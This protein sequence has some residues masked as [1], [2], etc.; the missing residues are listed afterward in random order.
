MVHQVLAESEAKLQKRA[1]AEGS[2]EPETEEKDEEEK[3]EETKKE[4]SHREFL[5]VADACDYLSRNF[6]KVAFGKSAEDIPV[7]PQLGSGVAPGGPQSAMQVE[8]NTTTGT[9][10]QPGQSG[11]ATSGNQIPA[12]TE[13][14][15]SPNENDAANAMPTNEGMMMA[16][17]PE[18][19]LKQAADDPAELSQR[20]RHTLGGAAVG[21]LKGSLA[22]V[23]IG[24]L[25]GLASGKGPAAGAAAGYGLGGVVGTG[26][27]GVKGY[28]HG[29]RTQEALAE[30][31]ALKAGTAKTASDRVREKF[32]RAMLG[33]FA[34]DALN[35]AKIEAG[36]EPILQRA[37]GTNP[38]Q[39]QGTPVGEGTPR[40]TAP[41]DGQGAGR[42]L[43]SSNMAAIG[44][45]K[46]DA[47]GPQKKPLAELL[48]EPALN[49]A[50][51]TVL[52]QSLDSTS[53][54]GVKIS[55]ARELLKAA[56]ASS[57]E[58]KA[59][60]DAMIKAAQGE[61]PPPGQGVGGEADAMGASTVSGV[62]DEALAAAAE[63]V[64][65]DELAKAQVILAMQTA[66]P[67]GMSEAG[68]EMGIPQGEGAGQEAVPPVE[69]PQ[70][71]A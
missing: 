52:N 46:R 3:E 62:S 19:V 59:I 51:D 2:G 26:V 38:A 40:E 8:P 20:L 22:G 34:E 50:H 47:K 17:Q 63:G 61:L 42:E 14:S 24:A 64:T 68:P 60:I 10:L 56:A 41:T 28:G 43:I 13:P 12:K 32:A 67:G 29:R 25:L 70:M 11:E 4:G 21:G 55:A 16:A 33:K 66:Q 69:P 71:P 57:P 9:S 5:K 7:D 36:T 45:T 49:A 1:S 23:P 35:P 53:S 54:A 65:T 37:E 44:Y 58:I 30:L 31:A 18:N 39:M 6:H 27:G 48:T 15:E